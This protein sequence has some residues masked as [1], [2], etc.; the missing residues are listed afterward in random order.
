[1]AGVQSKNVRSSVGV[2]WLGVPRSAV[3]GC[4]TA[5]RSAGWST[6]VEVQ[7]RE[8]CHHGHHAPSAQVA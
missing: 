8:V 7:L 1:M 3:G 6:L 5:G 2:E 4:S